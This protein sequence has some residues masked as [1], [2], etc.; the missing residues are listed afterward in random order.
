MVEM[1]LPRSSVKAEKATMYEERARIR[2]IGGQR[3]GKEVM[4]CART[5][6]LFAMASAEI[7]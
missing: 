5:A 7:S 6:S 3:Y 2:M 1:E 4:M